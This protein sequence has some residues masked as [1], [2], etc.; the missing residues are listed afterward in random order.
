MLNKTVTNANPSG[1]QLDTSL[2]TQYIATRHYP[3]LMVCQPVFSLWDSVSHPSSSEFVHR[4]RFFREIASNIISCRFV[5]PMI[6]SSFE[7]INL[8]HVLF[9]SHLSFWLPFCLSF[10]LK[11]ILLPYFLCFVSIVYIL[12]LCCVSTSSKYLPRFSSLFEN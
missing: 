8:S 2:P 7:I 1:T 3:S 6:K 4:A 5:P 9:I 12:L 10:F 11:L